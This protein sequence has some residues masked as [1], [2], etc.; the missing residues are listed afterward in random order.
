[1]KQRVSYILGMLR[2]YLETKIGIV[3]TM[4]PKPNFRI[5]LDDML[6]AFIEDKGACVNFQFVEPT[7]TP[8]F[9][10]TKASILNFSVK[11]DERHITYKG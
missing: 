11:V 1:M 9:V 5:Y 7:K 3:D 8:N 10:I 4:F 2:P 6:V